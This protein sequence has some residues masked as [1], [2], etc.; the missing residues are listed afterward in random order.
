MYNILK[1]RRDV[2]RSRQTGSSRFLIIYIY[3][4]YNRRRLVSIFFPDKSPSAP[5]H[6]QTRPFPSTFY[7]CRYPIPIRV[8]STSSVAIDRHRHKH[9]SICVKSTSGPGINAFSFLPFLRLPC[10]VYS[11]GV[12]VDVNFSPGRESLTGPDVAWKVIV[13]LSNKYR[14]CT[15]FFYFSVFGRYTSFFFFFLLS[16]YYYCSIYLYIPKML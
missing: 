4:Y 10:D 12:R 16:L 11:Y 14:I 2:Q 5:H 13:I 1:L 3:I 6:W 15:I 9:R 8:S 7:C